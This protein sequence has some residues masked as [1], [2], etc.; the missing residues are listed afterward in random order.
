M[1]LPKPCTGCGGRS[2]LLQ[3]DGVYYFVSCEQCEKL[4]PRASAPDDALEMWNANSSTM[5][6]YG[7]DLR[8]SRILK[9]L[10][11]QGRLDTRVS[12]EIPVVFSVGGPKGRRVT[13]TIRNI[14]HY[15][16]F[17]ELTGGDMSAVPVDMKELGE[18]ET[19]TFFK[20]PKPVLSRNNSATAV[21]M[22]RFKPR[23][24][25]QRREILGIGG[26]FI[27]MKKEHTEVLAVM[28]EYAADT[29]KSWQGTAG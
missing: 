19:Y 23:H 11:C 9:R 13:G 14:S 20:L 28:V 10:E 3:F 7:E 21:Q 18:L 26:C 12:L 25:H 22:F 5:F 15:G 1:E 4:G 6:L 8:K 27:N 24:M 17:L 16:A 2:V 29:L